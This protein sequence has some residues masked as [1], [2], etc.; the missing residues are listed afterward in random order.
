MRLWRTVSARDP[1]CVAESIEDP[2]REPGEGCP[3]EYGNKYDY[4]Y[5]YVVRQNSYEVRENSTRIS[6]IPLKDRRWHMLEVYF[7]PVMPKSFWNRK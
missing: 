1:D 5:M 3:L 2:N 7:V 6:R 4:P